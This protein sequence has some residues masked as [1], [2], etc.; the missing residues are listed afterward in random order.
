[1]QHFETYGA[2]EELASD[3]GLGYTA[4]HT[5]NFLK[6]WGSRHPLSSAYFPHSNLRAVQGVRVAKTNIRNN[7]DRSGNLDNDK[8]ARALLNYRNTPLKDIGRSP[9]QIVKGPLAG[10]PQQ[11]QAHQ[12]VAAAE[13]AARAG[14]GQALRP[15]GGE[16]V[17]AHQGAAQA[18]AGGHGGRAEPARQ[19]TQTLG[20][21][22]SDCRNIA[23]F[24]IQSENG[25]F[26]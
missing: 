13:G 12:G 24:A 18:A 8:F 17:R 23:A 25:R 20:Q 9:A 19:Q 2:S 1:M 5:Q 16:V 4:A 21:D 6:Q 3:G 15:H 26:W 14:A 11:L 10:Q 22:W 7:T